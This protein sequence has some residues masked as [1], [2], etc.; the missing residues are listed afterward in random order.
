VQA[1]EKLI[2]VDEASSVAIDVMKALHELD[3]N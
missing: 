3:D 2:G 1:I